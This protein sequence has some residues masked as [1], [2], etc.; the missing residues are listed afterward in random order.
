MSLDFVLIISFLGIFIG[1]I[2][3]LFFNDQK[4]IS[5]FKSIYTTTVKNPR[6]IGASENNLI[7]V[8][9]YD[10]RIYAQIIDILII[11]ML[12]IVNKNLHLENVELLF[13]I[14]FSILF[15]LLPLMIWRQSYGQKFMHLKVYSWTGKEVNN[16]DVV[17]IRYLLK[18]LIFPCSIITLI[19]NKILIQ[20][21]IFKTYEK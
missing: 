16:F 18:Y 12:I 9:N 1:L 7:S 5:L 2:L 14:L 6:Y 11:L 21:L 19:T 13:S 8:K 20:D 10:L 17:F 4:I 3:L 15:F